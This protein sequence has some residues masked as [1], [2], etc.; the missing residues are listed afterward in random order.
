MRTIP[1]LFFVVALFGITGVNAQNDRLLK[2]MNGREQP[3]AKTS[4]SLELG[5]S[6]IG[7]TLNFDRLLLETD[8]YKG[9]LRI[10]GGLLPFAQDPS[11]NPR[12]I[13]FVPLEYNNL[14]GPRNHFFEFS[15][16][17]VYT[18]FFHDGNFWMSGR[19]GYRVQPFNTGFFFRTGIVLLYIPYTNPLVY[20][21]ATQEV[22]LPI[23]SVAWGISF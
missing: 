17:A 10:G 18:N 19:V 9:T 3:L 11:E 4:L 12:A 5:G 8:F 6:G 1:Y 13:Y 2:E 23:P 21:S 20:P 22:W 16:G 7:Y 14:F 15:L